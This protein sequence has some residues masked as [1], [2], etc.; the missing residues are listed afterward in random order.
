MKEIAFILVFVISIYFASCNKKGGCL[1]LKD[2]I[3]GLSTIADTWS[4]QHNNYSWASYYGTFDVEG[5]NISC[6]IWTPHKNHSSPLQYKQIIYCDSTLLEEDD[7]YFSPYM[8]NTID[9]DCH[10]IL[11]VG[12]DY[13]E[14]SWR[15]TYE[16]AIKDDDG[17][18]YGF[19]TR[20][21]EKN[22]ADSIIEMWL[23]VDK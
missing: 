4:C 14:K 6:D 12:Y 20:S 8:Y 5:K 11:S 10:E 22:K 21:I 7:V 9:G 18:F 19:H 23:T 1:T 2:T 15:C 17:K 13:Y 16:Y 3:A